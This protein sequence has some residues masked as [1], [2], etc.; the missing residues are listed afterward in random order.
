MPNKIILTLVS[1]TQK[2]QSLLFRYEY[3]RSKITCETAEEYQKNDLLMCLS[4]P[5]K[6]KRCKTV[7]NKNI[8]ASLL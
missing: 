6:I 8:V 1:L 2:R 7:I 3:R 5:K 4:Y